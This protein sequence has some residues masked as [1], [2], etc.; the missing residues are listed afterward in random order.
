M[1]LMEKVKKNTIQLH[2][3]TL[4]E[5]LFFFKKDWNAGQRKHFVL[6]EFAKGILV[7]MNQEELS[8]KKITGT[9]YI[10]KKATLQKLGFDVLRPKG[11]L[12]VILIF[13]F[14]PL[15]IANSLVYK[16]LRF[17]NFSRI[18]SFQIK[19]A[20]LEKNRARFEALA[21]R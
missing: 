6:R 7:L 3:G 18:N 17:P 13:N 11:T 9:S 5:Y 12:F 1:L 15:T 10:L 2:G 19:I 21:G 14:F 4:L 8:E 16:K 20:D